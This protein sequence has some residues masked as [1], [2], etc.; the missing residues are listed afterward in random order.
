[1]IYFPRGIKYGRIVIFLMMSA[2][3]LHSFSIETPQVGG[4][5]RTRYEY[6][7][8]DNLNRFAVRNARIWI[9]GKLMPRLS[10]IV[11]TDLCEQGKFQFLDAYGKFVIGDAQM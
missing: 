6:M 5:L 8:L 11:S 7:T 10:Y 1:M 4:A 9:R 3:C 2:V